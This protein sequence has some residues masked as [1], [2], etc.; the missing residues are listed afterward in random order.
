MASSRCYVGVSGSPS[1]ISIPNTT[2][3]RSQTYSCG[4]SPDR[5]DSRDLAGYRV[6]V[7]GCGS[8]YRPRG[9]LTIELRRSRTTLRRLTEVLPPTARTSR[10]RLL[11]SQT[12]QLRLHWRYLLHR[13]TRVSDPTDAVQ[14]GF[15]E[16][17]ANASWSW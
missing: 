4:F 6:R 9:Y 15:V 2:S 10:S 7:Q 3:L 16:P 5:G 8:A 1:P 11:P 14:P 13:E 12:H 17:F